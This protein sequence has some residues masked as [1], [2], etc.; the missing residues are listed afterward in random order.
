MPQ[1]KWYSF[2]LHL[3][4]TCVHIND[5]FSPPALSL[6]AELFPPL[7]SPRNVSFSKIFSQL[8]FTSCLWSFSLSWINPLPN[9]SS[10][11]LNLRC[12]ASIKACLAFSKSVLFLFFTCCFSC[13]CPS[14]SASPRPSPSFDTSCS[15]AW[16]FYIV[17]HKRKQA[18]RVSLENRY[19]YNYTKTITLQ[20]IRNSQSQITWTANWL[21]AKVF[22]RCRVVSSTLSAFS[23]STLLS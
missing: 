8:F 19:R 21:I 3:F 7:Q 16:R 22:S 6:F 9:S 11:S 5:M 23:T 17:A 15:S 2:D 14:L 20:K 12:S 1:N 4:K 13:L 10:T 18:F